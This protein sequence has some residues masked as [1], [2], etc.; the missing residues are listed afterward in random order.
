MK[1]FFITFFIFSIVLYGINTFS[2]WEEI[3]Y[4]NLDTY[5]ER[6]YKI[7]EQKAEESHENNTADL[8]L[9]SAKETPKHEE[10]KT[11]KI[12]FLFKP[13]N[14]KELAETLYKTPIL[15]TLESEVFSSKIDEIV[16]IMYK[17]KSYV[18]GNMK[19]KVLRIYD[20]ERLGAEESFAVFLHELGHYID[21]YHFKKEDNYDM[22][23]EFYNI[24]WE[25]TKINKAGQDQ[26]DF[27]SWY[28][29]TNAYEDFSESFLYF[30]LHNNEFQE[31]AKNSEILQ[32]KYNFIAQWLF[33]SGIFQNTD[34]GD[35]SVNSYNRDITKLD[36]SLENFLEYM[37]KSI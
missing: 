23:H 32:N 21:L 26:D 3:Y 35:D 28:A 2:Q 20:P 27:V 9:L 11:D 8:A 25:T 13:E 16:I 37:K 14:F 10:E 19:N 4:D 31:K 33:I 17:N 7:I 36:F 18:R 24:S 34:F 30:I 22:S 12:I 1:I 15:Q 6:N 5:L 29:A